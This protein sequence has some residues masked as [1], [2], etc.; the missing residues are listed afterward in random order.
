M[1]D[2]GAW[3]VG[4]GEMARRIRDHDWSSTPLGPIPRWPQSLRTMVD[5]VL[6]MPSPATIL[7]R[8]SYVQL[9]NDPYRSIA[10][11][12]HPALLGKPVKEGWA[13]AYERAI[14]PLIEAAEAG[15]S[16]RL[17]DFPVELRSADGQSVQRVFDTDW[18][19]VRDETGAIAGCLQILVEST[20]RRET[21]LAL[22]ESDQRF[23]EFGE[24]STDVLWMRNAWT[25]EWTY[26][27]QA[28]EGIYG[29]EREKAL[30]G[31]TMHNWAELILAEDREHALAC[32]DRVRE[33]Q[34]AT[35]EYRIRRPSDGQVRWLRNTDFPI[36]NSDGEIVRIGGIGT[37]ITALKMA[38]AHQATL[39]AELQHRVRNTLAVVRSIA[40]R[41]AEN[42]TTAEDMLAHFQGRLDA[43][44]RVQA[45]LTRS[46]NATIDLTSLVEDELVAHA[47]RD[48]HQ[49]RI[50]GPAVALDP[51]T[52]ETLSLA[53]HELTTN[54]VKHGALSSEPGRISVR[55]RVEG[56]GASRSLIL[57]WAE[58]GV[59]LPDKPPKR[60]RF[61]MEL[62]RQSLPYELNAETTVELRSEGLRFELRMPLTPA[63]T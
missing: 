39:L 6:A 47:A 49:V 23:R 3:P 1:H 61:G 36:R 62:L 20:E 41:T 42:S 44:S 40:R 30:S 17:T 55:W 38:E 54:A 51:D 13:D 56:K 58:I 53:I 27:S 60:E 22:H 25:S 46:P 28:F 50:E 8:P 45:A 4:G 37:D 32:I 24:A 7:W 52:A 57:S 59:E 35:F 2:V 21:Q 29:L 14:A 31:D 63:E 12:R 15:R 43:F 19:P 16:T 11:D 10:K 18:S 48:G 9:Y 5:V 33:G 34:R 26:L